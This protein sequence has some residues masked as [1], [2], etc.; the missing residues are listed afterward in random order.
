MDTT[1][2]TTPASLSLGSF[3]VIHFLDDVW[4]GTRTRIFPSICRRPD[5]LSLFYA[6]ATNLLFGDS[7]GGKSW[8]LLF[9]A[10]QEIEAGHHVFFI[11]A[12]D[13]GI[14]VV[15][16]LKAIGL[17]PVLGAEKFHYIEVN[18]AWDAV[19]TASIMRGAIELYQPTVVFIDTLGEAMAAE[20]K[21]GISDL[22]VAEWFKM[23]PRFI[24]ALGPCV[25]LTDHIGVSGTASTRVQGSFRKRAA[26]S[27]SQFQLIPDETF[28]LKRGELGKSHLICRKDRQGAWGKDEHVAVF[29][30]EDDVYGKQGKVGLRSPDDEDK[31]GLKKKKKGPSAVEK[32]KTF[33]SENGLDITISIEAMKSKLDEMTFPASKTTIATALR[34]LRNPPPLVGAWEQ[35]EMREALGNLAASHLEGN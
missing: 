15:D 33:V 11:D 34:E 14:S 32:L 8:V 24:A 27:G 31:K 23:I 9:I 18:G 25:I 6:G 2:T 21:D 5:G 19:Q 10:K 7:A 16:R 20:G 26:L 28:P 35:N 17:D 1:E 13:S 22:A 4:A 12:E 30:L 3:G 29:T